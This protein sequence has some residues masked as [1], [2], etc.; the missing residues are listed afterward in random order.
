MRPCLF[1]RIWIGFKQFIYPLPPFADIYTACRYSLLLH[2]QME[3]SPSTPDPTA[4]HPVK[5]LMVD[6]PLENHAPPHLTRTIDSKRGIEHVFVLTDERRI[7]IFGECE[8]K[9]YCPPHF[10]RLHSSDD[11]DSCMILSLIVRLPQLNNCEPN[12]DN[13]RRCGDNVNQG[14]YRNVADLI[15]HLE[16]WPVNTTLSAS[17]ISPKTD[18]PLCV[19]TGQFSSS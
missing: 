16:T 7:S 5:Q 8:Y 12:S 1:A 17:C 2:P 3:T 6:N 18:C 10:L 11:I 15:H 4:D 14:I 9:P 13:Q 19:Y